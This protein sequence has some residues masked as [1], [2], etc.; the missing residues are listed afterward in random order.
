MEKNGENQLDQLIFFVLLQV[1]I[2][3]AYT[4]LLTSSFLMVQVSEPHSIPVSLSAVSSTSCSY[5]LSVVLSFLWMP[6]FE[7]FPSFNFPVEFG[8]CRKWSSISRPTYAKIRENLP[9][10]PTLCTPAYFFTLPIRVRT[11]DAPPSYRTSTNC[12]SVMSIESDVLESLN[13][14][15]INFKRL[16]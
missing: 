9:P 2:W 7:C 1:H 15:Y 8:I 16:C 12:L 14:D 4:C 3:N 5:F 11:F 10:P 6:L 13:F